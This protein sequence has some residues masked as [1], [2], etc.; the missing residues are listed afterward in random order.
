MG[1]RHFLHR[2][3]GNNDVMHTSRVIRAGEPPE[4][5]SVLHGDGTISEVKVS[6][7]N[8]EL[9]IQVDSSTTHSPHLSG[10]YM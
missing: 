3:P 10:G 9:N 2:G 8:D 1:F 5:I 4:W 6:A 7:D